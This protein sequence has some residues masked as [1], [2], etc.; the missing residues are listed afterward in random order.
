MYNT[1]VCPPVGLAYVAAA[2]RDAGHDVEVIDA[3]GEAPNRVRPLDDPSYLLRGLSVDEVAAR[4]S[5]HADV[6]G[7]SCMFSQDWPHLRGLL[8][9]LRRRAPG[10][11]IVA[12]SIMRIG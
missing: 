7:V 9:A 1:I 4:V 12:V 2:A 11:V 3:V 6:V 8:D 5:P 10:A